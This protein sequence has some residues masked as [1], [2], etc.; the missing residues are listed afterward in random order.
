MKVSIFTGA[1]VGIVVSLILG[2]VALFR[3]AEASKRQTT[4]AFKQACES[5]GGKAVWNFKYWECLK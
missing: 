3:E 1:V 5:K 2:F 4:E